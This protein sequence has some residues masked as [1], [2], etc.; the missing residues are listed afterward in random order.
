V[1]VKALAPADTGNPFAIERLACC[2]RAGDV[3]VIVAGAFWPRLSADGRQLV[4]VKYDP[5]YSS[6]ALFVADEDGTNALPL[7]LP[8]EFQAV[9]APMFSPDG[10]QVLFS[11]IT[12]PA[13]AGLTWLDRLLGVRPAFA[14]G[15]PS[16][17]WR[18]PIAGGAPQQ[19]T[20]I[21]DTGLYG[22]FSPDGAHV[23][24][25]SGTGLYV[26]NSDGSDIL[27]LVDAFDLPGSIGAASVDWIP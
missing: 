20:Q 12:L 21:A 14:D 17:W 23:A 24:F 18:I 25:I 5:V 10:A 16:D 22:S 19:I 11:A 1:H 3:E 8:A 9:D 2:P 27:S 15:S 13:S 7:A 4:Y 26:M 6:N